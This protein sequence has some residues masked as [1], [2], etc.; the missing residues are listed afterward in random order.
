[1]HQCYEYNVNYKFNDV[2]GSNKKA[3]WGVGSPEGC[4]HY[5]QS[6]PGCTFFSFFEKDDDCYVKVNSNGRECNQNHISGPRDCPRNAKP[7]GKEGAGKQWYD[8]DLIKAAKKKRRTV[9]S[10]TE[11]PLLSRSASM[12]GGEVNV[13]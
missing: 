8:P 3:K 6:T 13:E 12:L 9:T 10:T 5:C 2:G 7:L 4:Q 11:M 1:M